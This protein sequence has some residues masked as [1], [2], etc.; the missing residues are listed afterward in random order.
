MGSCVSSRWRSDSAP[1]MKPG[2]P[3]Y[4]SKPDSLD[5]P[6]PVKDDVD[7][8][9]S[10]AGDPKSQ[11]PSTRAVTNTYRDFGS[12]EV[13][14]DSQAWLDSDCDDEFLSVDGDFAPSRG[15]TPVHPSIFAGRNSQLSKSPLRASDRTT[16][17]PP[18]DKKKTLADLFRDSREGSFEHNVREDSRNQNMGT[19]N[20]A[21]YSEGA[22][23]GYAEPTR[24]SPFLLTRCCLSSLTSNDTNSERR[25]TSPALRRKMSG[26]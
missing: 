2:G 3:P 25:K 4:G 20:T 8:P 19:T 23:N 7:R 6:S 11:W 26:H 9:I 15:S 22:P 24:E 13:F 5:I 17:P 16:T 12:K 1:A 21:S 14:Y 10:D 18:S